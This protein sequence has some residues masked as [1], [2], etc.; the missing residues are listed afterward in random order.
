[1]I[2]LIS[3]VTLCCEGKSEIAEK[4]T[5]QY[6]LSFTVCGNMILHSVDFW[7]VKLA[8][9][10]Y[11]YHAFMDTADQSFLQESKEDEEA[12]QNEGEE[13]GESHVQ[14]LL[15]IVESL[16][17]D[18]EKYLN[19][20]IID[21][22]LVMPT[23]KTLSMFEMAEE[24]IMGIAI[25]FM[26]KTMV[27]KPTDIGSFDMKFFDIGKNLA[28][29]YYKATKSS[30]KLQ[31]FKLLSYMQTSENNSRYLSD[32]KHPA[33]KLKNNEELQKLQMEVE[34]E[35]GLG[36]RPTSAKSDKIGST[37]S[38]SCSAKVV[39]LCNSPWVRFDKE[40]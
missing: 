37:K 20:Q 40:R 10:K 18:F 31:I 7:P 6:I 8:V 33:K 28:S 34:D 22:E 17:E 23:G 15:K 13:V 5:K 21:H 32:V 16:N 14:T 36:S 24:Y 11:A 3:L 1:M 35:Q 12:S 19:D 25:E 38:S 9:L 29:L 30:H 26:H 27:R 2:E 39:E 4:Y